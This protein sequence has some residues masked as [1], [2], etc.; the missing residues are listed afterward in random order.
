MWERPMQLSQRLCTERER[1]LATARVHGARKVRVFGSVAYGT[2]GPDS[3]VDLLVDMEEGR[4][5][6]DLIALEQ[7]LAEL[8][9]RRVEVVT[10]DGLSPYLRDRIVAETVAL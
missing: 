10:D 6:L 4:D 1:I 8:L 2:D 9:G 7:Q 5:L 3:D